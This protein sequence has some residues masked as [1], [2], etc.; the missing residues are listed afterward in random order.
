ML[1]FVDSQR[2]VLIFLGV[3]TLMA[4]GALLGPGTD[5]VLDLLTGIVAAGAAFMACVRLALGTPNVAARRLWQLALILFGLV[6]VTRL[7]SETFAAIEPVGSGL[8]LSALA[9]LWLLRWFDPAAVAALRVLWLAYAVQ[10]AALAASLLS[11]GPAADFLTLISVQLYLLGTAS[12]V[13]SVRQMLS[14]S[15]ALRT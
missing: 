8:L 1:R 3:T 7:A 5:W 4:L 9:L 13:A 11:Q 15:V 6:C 14:S 10:V 2:S 12:F